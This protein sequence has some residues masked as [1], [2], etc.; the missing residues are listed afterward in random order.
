MLLL[1]FVG[2]GY[3]LFGV[4]FCG[5]VD[6]W[7][8]IFIVLVIFFGCYVDLIFEFFLIYVIWMFIFFMIVFGFGFF[9][10]YVSNC[11]Y[12]IILCILKKNEI[13]KYV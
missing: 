4:F 1:G 7:S 12:F 10:I 13:F 3:V 9:I 11:L 2:F 6:M 5:F 8:S